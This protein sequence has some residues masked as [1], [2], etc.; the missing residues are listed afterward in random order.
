MNRAP[1]CVKCGCEMKTARM[2]AVVQFNA[3][4][5][6]G[7]YEQWSGDIA[8][9]PDCGAEVVVAWAEQPMWRHH[10]GAEKRMTNVAVVVE[11]RPRVGTRKAAV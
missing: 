10:H 3:Q 8:K 6:G 4:S 5:V 7:A 9:C 1:V 2:G 11:E